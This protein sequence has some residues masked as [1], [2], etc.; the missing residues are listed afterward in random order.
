M[1]K[2]ISYMIEI[3][4]DEQKIE[5][6]GKYSIQELY[7]TIDMYFLNYGIKKIKTVDTDSGKSV[8]YGCT[9]EQYGNFGYAYLTLFQKEWCRTYL[10]KDKY[11]SRSDTEKGKWYTENALEILKQKM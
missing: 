3:I 9:E 4:L 7:K 6:D 1:D 5:S 10:K 8:F 2:T 11:Y